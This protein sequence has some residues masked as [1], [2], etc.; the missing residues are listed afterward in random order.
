ME[1]IIK[2]KIETAKGVRDFAPEEKIVRQEV[3]DTLKRVFERYGFSPLET[4]IIE[5]MEVLG[6]K[7]AAGE[8][9]DASKEIFKFKDQGERELGLRFDL[10]VPL[11]RFVSMNPN[12]KMPFKRYEIGRTYRD[13]PIKLGR[14]REFWQCD[15]DIVGSDEMLAEAE[16]MKLSLDV[17]KELGFDVYLELNNR[18]LLNGI[19]E[20]AGI[21]KEKRAQ[22]IIIIDKLKKVGLDEVKKELSKIGISEDSLEK[23]EKV[24]TL[25]GSNQDKLAKLKL[26]IKNGVGIEGINEL[27]QIYSYLPDDKN[28]VLNITLARGLAYYTGPVFEGFLRDSKITSSIC[29][30][31]RY[32]ELIGMY[33]GGN[34]QYPAT[35]ISFGLEPIIEAIKLNKKELSRSVA[36]VYV[37]P[38]KVVKEALEIA[39]QLRAAG[40]NTD[41]DIVDRGLSKNLDYADKLGIPFVVIV[42]PKDLENKEVTVRN[43]S[44]GEEKKIKIAELSKFEF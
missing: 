15:V 41:V 26:L 27:E 30:G 31:G 29:G 43:M 14:Y 13:G 44:S 12:L 4:P 11:S 36:K 16:L 34:K 3:V 9:S 2:M 35:G 40:I 5:R 24:L 6:A 42:G 8:D 37:I 20:Y 1:N 33:L 25:K 17:F 23:L 32:D 19:L 28:V 38:I 10:T 7:F 39:Q 22:A 18:K 21:T